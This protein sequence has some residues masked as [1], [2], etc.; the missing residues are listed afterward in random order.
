MSARGKPSDESILADLGLSRAQA[1]DLA[2]EANM[3]FA[4]IAGA[5]P[6]PIQCHVAVRPYPVRDGA[7]GQVVRDQ[8]RLVVVQPTGLHVAILPPAQARE[9]AALLTRSADEAEHHLLVAG[10]MP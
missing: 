6:V 8:V 2:A 3:A 1:E 9:L 10:G 4:A 5:Y 7:G